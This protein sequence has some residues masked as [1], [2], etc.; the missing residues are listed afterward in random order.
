MSMLACRNLLS[1]SLRSDEDNS[2]CRDA[3]LGE[4]LLRRV[5]AAALL[6]PATCLTSASAQSATPLPNWVQQSPATSPPARILAS[7]AYDST[8]GQVVLFG[9]QDAKSNVLGDTWT[10]DGTTWTQKSPDTSPPA[11]AGAAMAYDTGHQQVV[12]FGGWIGSKNVLGDTWTWNGTDWTLLRTAHAPSARDGM[13]MAYDT[14]HGQMVLFGGQDANSIVLGDT[15]TWN[16]TDWTL[17]NPAQSPPG[18]SGMG[19]AY[20]A[21]MSNVVIF[22]GGNDNPSVNESLDDTWMWDGTN[23]TQQSPN[24]SPALRTGP[25]MAYDTAH[26]EAVLFG[27]YD[28]LAGFWDDTWTLQMGP[29]NQALTPL[30]S[31]V[32]I[33]AANV[34]PNGEAAPAPCSQTVTVSYRVN[35]TI[36]FGTV[37]VLTQ[38][39]PNLDFTLSANTC[40]GTVTSPATCAVTVQFAP[41]YPGMRVGAIELADSDGNPLASTP[42]YGTGNAPQVAFS[43]GMGSVLNT[44][45]LPGTS[46]G[47]SRHC[48]SS[49]MC[50]P[51]GVAT[52]GAGNVYIADSFNNRVVKVT[53]SGTA[54]VLN[55]PSLPE[56]SN[57]SLACEIHG[58]CNPKSLAADGAG[59]IYIADSDNNRVVKITPSG[60]AVALRYSSKHACLQHRWSV[61]SPGRSGR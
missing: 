23:W 16:G 31:P 17:R 51:R 55:L 52:D 48:L 39:A 36:T 42:V 33:D 26:A 49:G 8:H 2:F 14:A 5:L 59:N 53:P 6:L 28:V 34:C 13:S 12:L 47:Q 18:R 20:D 4:R 9:G 32:G 22:G 37:K 40:A 58:L 61:F 56:G 25:A 27:G 57:G 38:G 41:M 3:G 54:E 10:W 46:S 45:S 15:W 1:F 30:T 19:M 43:P 11:R 7:M 29:A 50:L 60:A 35:A 21:A 44:S 24:T